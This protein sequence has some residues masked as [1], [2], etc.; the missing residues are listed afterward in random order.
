MKQPPRQRPIKDERDEQI[1]THSKSEALD[2]MIAATQVL[3]IMCLI[4]GNP[5]WKGSLALLF[6]GGVARLFYKYD[7]Y[8]E[9]PYIQVGI[10]L[11]LL[12]VALFIWFGITG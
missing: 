8:E 7:K 5:A 3:T 10:M 11:G 12:G 4:K 1:D 9:K 6:I 2:F